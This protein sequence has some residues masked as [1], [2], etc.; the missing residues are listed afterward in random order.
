MR[1]SRGMQVAGQLCFAYPQVGSLA[2]RSATAERVVWEASPSPV[3]GARLLSGLR[4]QPSRGFKSRRLRHTYR[5]VCSCQ[6]LE[7]AETASLNWW[8]RRRAI[9]LGDSSNCEIHFMA[10]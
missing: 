3:Y 1:F 9:S 5:W 4:A 2:Q 8:A 6:A 10:A 7:P